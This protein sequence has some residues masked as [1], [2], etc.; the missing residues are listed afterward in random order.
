M[1]GYVGLKIHHRQ[2]GIPLWMAPCLC[3]DDYEHGSPL[4][5]LPRCPFPQPH[6]ESVTSRSGGQ[7]GPDLG[8]HNPCHFSMRLWGAEPIGCMCG[9]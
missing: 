1:L 3:L 6:P 2:S 4:L 8:F 5:W 7:V 9:N